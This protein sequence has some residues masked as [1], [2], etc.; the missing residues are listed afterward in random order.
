[1]NRTAELI[2]NAKD[3]YQVQTLYALAKLIGI[4]ENRLH[5]YTKDRIKPDAYALTR[6]ALALDLDP[7]TVIAEVSA[8]N[9]K[10]EQKREFWRNFLTRA[11]SA[12]G[13]LVA[14]HCGFPSSSE[15]EE[16]ASQPGGKT[17]RTS[18]YAYLVARSGQSPGIGFRATP[19][20]GPAKNLS[21]VG[22]GHRP[23]DDPQPI[24]ARGKLPCCQWP[25]LAWRTSRLASRPSARQSAGLRAE[26][27]RSFTPTR[28]A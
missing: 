28:R 22:R 1:M 13:L 7:L 25:G 12:V 11:A 21:G 9:E 27:S 16:T 10:S 20:G 5:D 6:L 2:Q 4:P 15:A 24:V 26:N 17:D 19:T 18:K 23:F 8:E 14:L 3:R